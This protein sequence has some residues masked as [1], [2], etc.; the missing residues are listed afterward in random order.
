MNVEFIPRC[1]H[2]LDLEEVKVEFRNKRHGTARHAVG[3]VRSEELHEAHRLG[4]EEAYIIV[5]WT[6]KSNV[7]MFIL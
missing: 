6:Q 1:A 7:R 4:V 2:Q 5:F 3:W